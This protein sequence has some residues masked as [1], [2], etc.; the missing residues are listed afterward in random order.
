MI[1]DFH[2]HFLSSQLP[3]LATETGDPRWPFVI[4]GTKGP[5]IGEVRQGEDVFR[6]VRRPF[7][8]AAAR[9][10]EMDLSGTDVQVISPIPVALCYWAEPKLALR[11][12]QAQNDEIAAAAQSSGGRLIGLGTVPLQAPDLAIREMARCVGELGLAGLELG[13]V[14]GKWELDDLELRPFFRAAAEGGVPLFLHPIDGSGAL[15]CS[16]PLIDFAVGMHTDTSLAATALVYGGVL[17]ELPELRICLSHGGGAFPWTY[18][19]LRFRDGGD[20]ERSDALV[21]RLWADCL[22]FDPLHVPLLVARYGADHLVLGSDYPFLAN[23]DG[24]GPLI[25]AEAMGLLSATDHV[26][27]AGRNSLDFLRK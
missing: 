26:G 24:R 9:V 17:A 12:S 5:E 21:R 6:V 7:W 10:A 18:P 23:H 16:N 15:R 4:R 13:T 19:R 20:A 14:V 8:D 3:D 22:V 2:T 1:V 25:D 11:F 27:I